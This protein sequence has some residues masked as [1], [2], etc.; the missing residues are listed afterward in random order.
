MNRCKIYYGGKQYEISFTEAGSLLELVHGAGLPVSA[1]CGGNGT[2]GKCRV[3]A[4]GAL[5]PLTQEELDK[6]SK[7]EIA[8]HVRLACCAK[9]MGDVEI[10]LFDT[11]SAQ[12]LDDFYQ[13]S[14]E[15]LSPV[16]KVSEVTLPAPGLIGKNADCYRLADALNVP[17]CFTVNALREL[18]CLKGETVQTVSYQNQIISITEPANRYRDN[19]GLYL[20]SRCHTA[21]NHRQMYPSQRAKPIWC[22]RD[23]PYWRIKPAGKPPKNAGAADWADQRNDPGVSAVSDYLCRQYHHA[24]YPAGCKSGAYCGS[25]L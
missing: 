3:T 15:P 7:E 14:D 24:A 2:C 16:L 9:P 23:F 4:I 1:P 25:A 21:E 20:Y 18:S 6:L 8:E 11:A 17:V 19:D 10:R 13:N 12:I 22:G 5:S